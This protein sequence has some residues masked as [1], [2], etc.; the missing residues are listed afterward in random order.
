MTYIKPET[1]SNQSSLVK[2]ILVQGFEDTQRKN[3]LGVSNQLQQ[4]P[5]TKAKG[6]GKQF[7]LSSEDW[8]LAFEISLKMLMEG[9]FQ[10]KW[11]I[12][13]L[14]PLLGNQIVVPL[15][16]L[17]LDQTVESEVRWF[18]CQILGSFPQQSVV[19]TLVQLLQQ[20]TD[21]ELI[22]IAGKTLIKIGD[23][24]IKALIELLSQPEHAL[25][26]VQSLSYIRTAET[27][28]PLLEVAQHEDAKLRAIAINA[29]GSFHDRRVTPVLIA[30][31]QD[32]A[33]Q[34]RKEAAIAL[35]FRCDLCTEIDLVKHL[36]PLLYDLNLE[37]CRQAVVS[38]GR[39]HQPQAATT[40]FEVLQGETTPISLKLDIVKA[41]GWSKLGEGIVYLEK[42]LVNSSELII[43]EIIIVLGRINTPELKH[44]ATQVL[45]NYW[46]SQEQLSPNIRQIFATS[47][48][49][50]G[51][52][53]AQ[54]VLEQLASDSDRKV[55]LHGIAALKKLS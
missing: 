10:H 52:S 45:I 54:P 16:S 48:G 30:G 27:I 41:L 14:F 39:M 7:L 43:Q 17:A 25:L 28:A 4:L 46:Q 40:L 36:Q 53:I 49:E 42:A 21:R 19:L 37:V 20:S 35:G 26:A 33:S 24:S 1:T 18:I 15:N 6:S 13:K 50:L 51:D 22:E 44:Q 3:W 32:R 8:D 12:T 9:D 31:L 34:V 23:R 55:Q 11:E 29:L 2:A 5:Q 38:L 47:L